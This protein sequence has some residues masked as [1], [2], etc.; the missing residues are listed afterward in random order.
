MCQIPISDLAKVSGP[1]II[2]YH[3]LD[4]D[5]EMGMKYELLKKQYSVNVVFA[6]RKLTFHLM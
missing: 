6:R 1:T 5:P 4:P 2:G 3:R